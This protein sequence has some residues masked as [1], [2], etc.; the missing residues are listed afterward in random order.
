MKQSRNLLAVIAGQSSVVAILVLVLAL[1]IAGA[2][3]LQQKQVVAQ[4]LGSEVAITKAYALTEA[5]LANADGKHSLDT[6][7]SAFSARHFPGALDQNAAAPTDVAAAS[8]IAAAAREQR[9]F[10]TSISRTWPDRRIC[11]MPSP[12]APAAHC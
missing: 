1:S 4:N 5:V 2:P 10:R 12:I 8:A 11:S 9:T 3:M 7:N 6:F